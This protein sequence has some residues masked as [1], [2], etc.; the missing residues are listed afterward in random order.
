M[1]SCGPIHR[2]AAEE[3]S[4]DRGKDDKKKQNRGSVPPRLAHKIIG[5]A[6]TMTMRSWPDTSA[7]FWLEAVSTFQETNRAV[8]T[9]TTFEGNEFG[10]NTVSP[11]AGAPRRKPSRSSVWFPPA[12]TRS[13]TPSP[14]RS[15]SVSPEPSERQPT[16]NRPL[17]RRIL[18]SPE[19][20]MGL[21]TLG[22]HK[23]FSF[24]FCCC[25]LDSTCPLHRRNRPADGRTPDALRSALR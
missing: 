24:L 23:R 6:R 16:P 15:S 5:E 8:S 25:P 22:R 1:E 17:A 2:V 13:C 18:P 7:V 19:A 11:R 4:E 20:D 21:A 3:R 10:P 12:A 9:T 14:P